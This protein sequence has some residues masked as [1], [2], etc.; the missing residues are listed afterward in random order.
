LELEREQRNFVS[1][2]FDVLVLDAFS[3]DAIPVHLL[4]REAF[5]I[6]KNALADGGILAVHV[7]NRHFNLLPQVARLGVD[8][9]F[10][11]L[12]LNTDAAR[13]N[14]SSEA[15][16]IM[17]SDRKQRLVQL[18]TVMRRRVEKLGLPPDHLN[19]ESLGDSRLAD[20]PL[21]TDDYSDLFGA[22][23]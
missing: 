17:L 15:S 2:E 18:A 5:R 10:P 16:W 1:Q 13:H 20:V 6:Y 21:W 3:S 12:I 9:G 11:H 22:L 8:V 19:L 7:S 4:T 23:K 14:R